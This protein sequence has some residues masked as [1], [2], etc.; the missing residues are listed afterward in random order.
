M[1]PHVHLRDAR[2]FEIGQHGD[3]AVQL[4]IQAHALRDL[5]PEDL[6][7]A[8]IVL[9]VHAAELAD[10]PV[11]DAAGNFAQQD[12]VLAVG[13]DAG[14]QI[15]VALFGQ[16]EHHRNVERIVLQ[17][18]V[19]RDDEF[20]SGLVD[21]SHQRQA[22]TVVFPQLDDFQSFII[23]RLEHVERAIG[24]AV[25]HIDQLVVEIIQ[26]LGNACHEGTHVVGLV[27]HG[28]DH[29]DFR[30][31]VWSHLFW[32][33]SAGCSGPTSMV[34]WPWRILN[35]DFT[36]KGTRYKVVSTIIHSPGDGC[37]VRRMICPVCAER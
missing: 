9:H 7:R 16:I 28:H 1:M 25:I 14:H 20:A 13:A 35:V 24:R 23:Y 31:I 26:R 29:A 15:P 36:C 11:G 30:A 2:P 27:V 19:E 17:I 33:A 22:L 34:R 10:D 37:S 21:A 5:G 6:Q 8:A 4:A 3:E 18:A 12:V 32:I